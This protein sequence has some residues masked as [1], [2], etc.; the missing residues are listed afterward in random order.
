[1]RYSFIFFL[2][3]FSNLDSMPCALNIE[4][5]IDSINRKIQRLGRS[6]SVPRIHSPL[7]HESV[8][9][10]KLRERVIKN[11]SEFLLHMNRSTEINDVNYF[12]SLDYSEKLLLDI[13][14][15]FKE[16]VDFE[17]CG[18]YVIYKDECNWIDLSIKNTRINLRG[19]IRSC[20]SVRIDYVSSLQKHE[21]ASFQEAY[22]RTISLFFLYLLQNKYSHFPISISVEEYCCSVTVFIDR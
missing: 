1:M 11:F 6:G 13:Y 4:T 5:T 14:L 19:K 3:F 10:E 18:F 7:I 16:K 12:F 9:P 20:K 21:E 17:R 8:S 15:G 22:F 2:F